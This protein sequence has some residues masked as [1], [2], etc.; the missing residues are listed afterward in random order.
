MIHL[1]ESLPRDTQYLTL[2]HRWSGSLLEQ[3]D[4]Y[5]MIG[6]HPS[7]VPMKLLNS[8]AGKILR[9]AI[10]ITRILG[11]RYLWIDALCINQKDELEKAKEIGS[12]AQIYARAIVN[13]SATGAAQAEDG[14]FFERDLM[15]STPCRRMIEH[16]S[17]SNKR[18]MTIV[19]YKSDWHEQVDNGPLNQR[20]WVFQERML[21]PRIIHFARRQV[22]WECFADRASEAFPNGYPDKLWQQQT[23]STI[24]YIKRD[25][26]RPEHPQVAEADLWSEMVRVYSSQSLTFSKD[27]L[28]A[29]SALAK[30]IC[31]LRCLSPLNYVAGHWDFDLPMSLLWNSPRSSMQRDKQEYLAP[32]WS[33]ASKNTGAYPWG[34]SARLIADLIDVATCPKHE[35]PFGEISSGH[36]ILCC[37][38]SRMLWH[39][40]SKSIDISLKEEKVWKQSISPVCDVIMSWDTCH[41][42]AGQ[43]ENIF[44]IPQPDAQIYIRDNVF[45]LAPICD[46]PSSRGDI[47]GLILHRT[48]RPGQYVRVGTFSA[49]GKRLDAGTYSLHDTRGDKRV[50]YD[51]ESESRLSLDRDNPRT[52]LSQVLLSS[53]RKLDYDDYLEVKKGGGCVI[54]IV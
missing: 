21:A 4:Q 49:F 32:S 15:P 14:L 40:D 37:S 9:H 34:I 45:H 7:T 44:W 24:L 41:L 17:G 28:P 48:G 38:L 33:W 46:M 27:R 3:L 51:V 31:R 19:A 39:P 47:Y 22:F 54:E 36:L 52:T 16:P 25:I 29:I 12:M 6:H 1:T 18:A 13:I 2:S 35:D 11:Y 42:G 10:Q 53:E 26:S 23:K 20:A 43:S 8:P 30:K 5:E 50:P